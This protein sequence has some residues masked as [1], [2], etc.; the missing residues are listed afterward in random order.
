MP[1]KKTKPYRFLGLGVIL[2]ALAAVLLTGCGAASKPVG[3]QLDPPKQ[4]EEIAVITTSEG[5]I[6]MRLFEDAA[7]KTVENFKELAQQ[8]FYDGLTFHRVIYDFM[9]QTGDGDGQSIYGATFEDEFQENLLNLRGAVSM[10]NT[11]QPDT[12]GTQFFINQSTAR[13]FPGWEYYE[14]LYDLYEI[15][16]EMFASQ[17]S[18]NPPDF[19]KLTDEVKTLYEENGGNPYL[20]GA[21]T[22]S[23]TGHTVFGQVFD[24]MDVVDAIA[25]VPTDESARPLEDVTI[26]SIEITTYEGE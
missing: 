2:F 22:V 23:G 4:G 5:V 16:A 21:Y 19:S 18:I 11:G 8:G 10:A 13:T 15:S 17:Y 9:I 7:P 26:E 3:Y 20:D 12:N 6:R 14:S 24:G 25:S 1:M